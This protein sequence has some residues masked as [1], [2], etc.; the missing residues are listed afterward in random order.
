MNSLVWGEPVSPNIGTEHITM[1]MY[2]HHA[3]TR[4]V[5][6]LAEEEAEKVDR[7]LQLLDTVL[8]KEV[9]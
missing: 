3:H 5:P 4:V 8:E 1:C 6:G 2:A 7:K 9:M